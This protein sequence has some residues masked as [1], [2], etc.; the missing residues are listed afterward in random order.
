M[1]DWTPRRVV[2]GHDANGT[3][4]FLSDGATLERV[5]AATAETARYYG[6]LFARDGGRRP[7]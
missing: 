1:S 7:R 5:S 2:T 6:A 4:V 3:S